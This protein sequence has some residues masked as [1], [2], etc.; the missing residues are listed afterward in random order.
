MLR[1]GL[2][3]GDEM[4]S[5]HQALLWQMDGAGGEILLS[6]LQDGKEWAMEQ[7]RTWGV[8]T[9]VIGTLHVTLNPLR[10]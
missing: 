10:Q 7:E 9:F 6:W 2:E 3:I 5:L 8:T 1:R 4:S